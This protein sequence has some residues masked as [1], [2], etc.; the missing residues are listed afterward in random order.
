MSYKIYAMFGGFY[1]L[2]SITYNIADKHN[3][4]IEKLGQ[5]LW[6]SRGYK[7]EIIIQICFIIY[8]VENQKSKITFLGGIMMVI[9]LE[10]ENLC[11]AQTDFRSLS[12]FT[13]EIISEIIIAK[14]QREYTEPGDL[15]QLLNVLYIIRRGV[16]Y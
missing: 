1:R 3:Q 5:I 15:L 6:N 9:T 11:L 14:K 16:Y 4:I 13:D 2:N 7:Y 8:V 12:Q 10:I